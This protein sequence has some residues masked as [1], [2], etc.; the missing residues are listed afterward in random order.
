MSLSSLMATRKHLLP[1]SPPPVAITPSNLLSY[2]IPLRDE[3]TE[4]SSQDDDA[5]LSSTFR[6][7]WPGGYDR[8]LE[9][10][11][12]YQRLMAESKRV[13]SADTTCTNDDD[14]S[15][16]HTYEI[17]NGYLISNLDNSDV[18]D[19]VSDKSQPKQEEVKKVVKIKQGKRIFASKTSGLTNSNSNKSSYINN[20]D[21]YIDENNNPDQGGYMRNYGSVFE[22]IR[23]L[24]C[25]SSFFHSHKMPDSTSSTSSKNKAAVADS[26]FQDIE[27]YTNQVL[28]L[29]EQRNKN[30]QLVTAW[31]DEGRYSRVQAMT[32]A[33]TLYNSKVTDAEIRADLTP[34][35]KFAYKRFCL[36]LDDKLQTVSEGER[37]SERTMKKVWHLY[38]LYLKALSEEIWDE[39]SAKS[40]VTSRAIAYLVKR[41][42][43]GPEANRPPEK[44]WNWKGS[45]LSSLKP[46]EPVESKNP[47]LAKYLS[48]PICG[49][50]IVYGRYVGSGKV[51]C[52]DKLRKLSFNRLAEDFFEKIVE[53][54]LSIDIEA[55]VLQQQ[56][57]AT[58]NKN[59]QKSKLSRSCEAKLALSAK[60][61]TTILFN[62][63]K[64]KGDGG[65]RDQVDHF[66]ETT[67]EGDQP[68]ELR[69]IQRKLQMMDGLPLPGTKTS[70]SAATGARAVAS[71]CRKSISSLPPLPQKKIKG[72]L[73][74]RSIN[75]HDI[76]CRSPKNR[77]PSVPF[78]ELQPEFKYI[79]RGKFFPKGFIPPP[80]VSPPRPPTPSK[81]PKCSTS[82][83]NNVG[84]VV[85]IPPP[86]KKR[87]CLVGCRYDVLPQVAKEM[88]FD[89]VSESDLWN[90]NWSDSPLAPQKIMEM[91]RI[92]DT[93]SVFWLVGIFSEI[94]L[95]RN[96]NRL[97]KLFPQD[98]NFFPPTWD[99]P[100]EHADLVSFGRKR[101][102]A[103]Y[104]IKPE[105]GCQGKGIFLIRDLKTVNVFA[106]CVCQLY[107]P[108]PFLIDGYKF[109]QRIYVLITCVDPLR[110][111]IYDEGIA[112]FATVK[113]NV[114][115]EENLDVV[116]MHLTNYSL[117]KF[118]ESYV[119]EGDGSKR[120]LSSIYK[121]MRENGFDVDRLT[122][123]ID[124][125]VVKTLLCASPTLQH[126]YRTSFPKRDRGC[127][128]FEVLGF[129]ILMDRHLQPILLEVNHSPSFNLD[130]PVDADVKRELLKDLLKMVYLGDEPGMQPEQILRRKGK[131]R[132]SESTPPGTPPPAYTKGLPTALHKQFQ[133]EL[134]RR[135]KFRLIYT[136][137]RPG[138]Y[139]KFLDETYC[140]Y[141]T[142]EGL[143]KKRVGNVVFNTDNDKEETWQPRQTNSS[144]K[145]T[146]TGQV[147]L[148]TRVVTPPIP[149]QLQKF[150][151]IPESS[152]NAS[153]H[154]NRT[155]SKHRSRHTSTTIA[156][157]SRHRSS[158]LQDYEQTEKKE[159][160][161][162]AVT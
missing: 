52:V 1:S 126:N 39:G 135:G 101:K 72:L 27:Q 14:D 136:A 63:K 74:K 89:V 46:I 98:Y 29:T 73:R 13:K 50:L 36:E 80:I 15:I 151:E 138:K 62:G 91:R 125:I 147:Y 54:P 12:D 5:V 114:P 95:G 81:P 60:P 133:H 124:D 42:I 154:N 6:S 18:E 111:Y 23:E 64:Q 59:R 106:K 149:S 58:R 47:V 17:L 77:P 35:E 83:K 49:F 66:E 56:F 123:S 37:M 104:I 22:Q 146:K 157:Q 109:D 155:A 61:S 99:L 19:D 132:R 57:Y 33:C 153:K 159:K 40:D 20:D 127:S 28:S 7:A 21:E 24:P 142:Q 10:L 3:V 4:S 55:L 16:T 45:A 107:V 160:K 67:M 143:V 88:G 150:R 82:L 120:K 96:L 92:Q 85:P 26:K 161:V 102:N 11:E 51:Q 78:K 44:D 121:W 141:M 110:L 156:N 41:A 79:L 97:K 134:A 32:I 108:H 115:S 90:I 100:T 128:C 162:K 118:S 103:T 71:T 43:A 93:H 76:L 119:P 130:L 113:Y 144:V 25:V 94:W 117:N 140:G 8:P 112:R 137:D 70:S 48:D 122:K 139:A 116:F 34:K 68:M 86:R 152:R 158:S 131:M 87:I 129:D 145:M 148:E 65:T 38:A 9:T 30:Y 31:T 53:P 2:L 84:E 75:L 69:S 105:S